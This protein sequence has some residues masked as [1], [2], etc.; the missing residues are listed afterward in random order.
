MHTSDD[1]GTPFHLIEKEAANFLR[2]SPRTLQRHRVAG[3]G[4]DFIR[5]GGR[6]LYTRNDLLSWVERN[7]HQSTSC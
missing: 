4:P 2:L 6:V 7:R 5:L 3:T 1:T